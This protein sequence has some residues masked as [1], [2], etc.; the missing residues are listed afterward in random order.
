M[1][2]LDTYNKY[3]SVPKEAQKTIGGGRLKGMT[4]I[5]PMWR[6]KSLTE[7]YGPCGIGWFVEPLDKWLEEGSGGEVAAFMSINL[8]VKD[9][10]EW[11]KPIF[12]VG[13]SMFVAQ[14]REG[15][16]NSDE[17]Y[18]MAHTDALS[19]CCKMLGFGADIY[20][21]TKY[22]TPQAIKK[23]T[24]DD[25]LGTKP[26]CSECKKPITAGIAS[27]SKKNYG[28]YLCPTCQPNK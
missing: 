27:Y 14:E 17:C 1:S 12:G 28:K 10:N 13:G 8:Y 21:Q 16:H 5:N 25:P 23:S 24:D 6:I 18:K 20:W 7:K 15:L 26:V 4:D 3:A 19:V 11:S 9:G 2:N 22:T